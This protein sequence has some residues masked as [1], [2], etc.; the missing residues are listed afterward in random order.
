MKASTV[1]RKDKVT[2]SNWTKADIQGLKKYIGDADWNRLLENKT[3]DEAWVTFRKT[4]DL[5]LAKF[6]PRSTR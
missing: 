1:R 6:V 3:V 4:L 2:R 5:A